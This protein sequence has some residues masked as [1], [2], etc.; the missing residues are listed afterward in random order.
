MKRITDVNDFDVMV[1]W[2]H[3]GPEVEVE[4]GYSL[5]NLD[6]EFDAILTVGDEEVV[7]SSDVIQALQDL[8]DTAYVSIIDDPTP[9]EW[10]KLVEAD[11]TFAFLE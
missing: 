4:L 1:T 6:L 3:N 9:L 8:I 10:E 2:G 11:S 5:V 7:V